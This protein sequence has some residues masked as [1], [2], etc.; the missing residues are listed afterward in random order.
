M[1]L[2]EKNILEISS[3]ILKHRPHLE[4]CIL[5]VFAETE[6]MQATNLRKREIEIC[7]KK[8]A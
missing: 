4:K 6:R 3:W 7:P 2:F 5:L 8:T 1:S